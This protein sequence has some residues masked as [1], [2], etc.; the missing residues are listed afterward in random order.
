MKLRLPLS[1]KI[2][3]WFLVN[4]VLVG[5]ALYF[6]VSAQ[7]RPGL[8]SF[9][10][11]QADNRLDSVANVILLE[12]NEKPREVWGATLERFSRSYR[13]SF[14]LFQNNGQQMAG[15]AVTLP[16]EVRKKIMPQNGG[17]RPPPPL[18]R[19][20]HPMGDM[21]GG[22]P[23]EMEAPPRPVQRQMDH[24]NKLLLHTAHPSRYWAVIRIPLAEP[25]DVRH[26]PKSLVIQAETLG[27]GGLFFDYKPWIAGGLAILGISILWWLPLIFGMTRAI[28]RLTDATAQIAEGRFDVR[29]DDGRGD[30][31]GTLA[32]SVNRMAERLQGFVAGQKRFLGDIAHELCAPLARLQVGISI[33]E[34]Q[35]DPE[36]TERVQDLREEIDH[37][38][39]LVNELLSFS[40]A[41][42]AGSA[43]RWEAVPL[44]DLIQKVLHR[45]AASDAVQVDLPEGLTVRAEPE[46][47]LRAVCNLVRN[48]LR[49]A[50]AD[51][52][53][54]ITAEEAGGVVLLRVS[55]CG[56]GIPPDTLQKIFD[57]F[58]RVDTSRDRNTGGV[59]L[60][61][62]IVKTCVEACGGSVR[63]SL[64]E[65]TGLEVMLTLQPAI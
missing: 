61:L 65:P 31:L 42:L 51:G 64:R 28:R 60:G 24:F 11:G 16:E 57:P 13:V 12:L 41:S 6:F 33:L 2:L 19:P 21:P 34:Q 14:T 44:T 1:V 46:L 49:Y 63:C 8:D 15:P 30:E 40:K 3:V 62:A 10:S 17:E 25:G 59:G 29:L 9:L 43:V 7:F 39:G 32:E 23:P 50:G 58:Y 36:G 5:G 47:L 48:A 38:A 4:L 54:T 22:F 18:D 37:M 52:P 56:P 55:D 20:P 27:G 35:A 45:E 26:I 53:I